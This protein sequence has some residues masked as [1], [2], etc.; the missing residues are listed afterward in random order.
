[1]FDGAVNSVELMFVEPRTLPSWI[2]RVRPH[3]AKMADGS[4]GR[5]LHTDILTE[6]AS[7]R[8]QLWVIVEG[9]S[10][11]CVTVT[12][13]K[14]FPRCRE[15]WII[16]LVGYRSRRWIHLLEGLEL[17]AKHDFGCVKIAALHLPRFSALL[18]NYGMTHHLS[19]KPL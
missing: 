10:L 13:V 12:E 6:I 14:Q 1:M 9:P 19:E 5:Y 8:M 15:M 4:S 16:G 7:G 18:R 17:S 11:L 3:L 2:D